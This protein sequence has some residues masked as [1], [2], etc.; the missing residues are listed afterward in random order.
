MLSQISVTSMFSS[1]N[2]Q[3]VRRA[4]CKK[5]RVSS[6]NTLMFFPASTAARGICRT[7]Q[8]RGRRAD[9]NCR[10]GRRRKD[11]TP[12]GCHQ[13]PRSPECDRGESPP[14]TSPLAEAASGPPAR[15][16]CPGRREAATVARFFRGVRRTVKRADG[17]RP[18]PVPPH[19]RCVKHTMLNSLF[20]QARKTSPKQNA[21]T[22]V[23]GGSL[24]SCVDEERSQLRELM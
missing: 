11:P 20:G 21:F 6:A 19:T 16:Q 1:D 17:T 4:P 3:A 10:C 12:R 22:T 8:G 23:C 13:R 15:L 2:S 18:N 24:G 14:S 5:G 9:R 7:G